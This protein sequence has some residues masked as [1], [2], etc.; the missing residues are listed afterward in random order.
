MRKQRTNTGV[1]KY[2]IECGVLENGT[3][4]DIAAARRKYWNEYTRI[5]QRKKRKQERREIVV[6]FDKR[7]I[8][9][10]RSTA[11]AKS[12]T[13]QD[14]IRKCV[15]ADMNKSIVIPHKELISQIRQAIQQCANDLED[16]KQREGKTWF[17]LSRTFDDVGTILSD[18]HKYVASLIERQ[19]SV[20]QSIKTAL[21]SNPN[22][23][24]ELISIMEE[25]DYKVIDKKV[26]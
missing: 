18:T 5:R 19:Q 20:Q 15:Q 14:Y 16:I 11:K 26:G 22:F 2:L 3:D 8:N 13:I 12:Y 9:F 23:I 25:Y 1:Y 21:E 24:T 17:T 7:D 6:T 10:V 4:E